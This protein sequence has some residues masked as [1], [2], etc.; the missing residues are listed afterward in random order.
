MAVDRRLLGH[1]EVDSGTL[2]VGDPAY[3]LPRKDH[4]AGIGWDEVLAAQGSVVRL[5]QGTVVLLQEFGGDGTFPVVGEYEDGE[6]LRVVVE[7]VDPE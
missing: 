6:L 7:F 5:A 2:L 1:V 4:G 3:V